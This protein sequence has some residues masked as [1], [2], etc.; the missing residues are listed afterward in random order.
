MLTLRFI[1]AL[2]FFPA[3]VPAQTPAQDGC[4]VRTI[5]AD[6]KAFAQAPEARNY[7]LTKID[8]RLLEQADAMDQELESKG[9]VY[10]DSVTDEYVQRIG[11]SVTPAYSMEKVQ[12]RF[13]VLRDPGVNA[14]ALLFI[15]AGG[16]V[17]TNG[18]KAFN[19]AGFFPF[20]SALPYDIFGIRIGLVDAASG[21]VLYY[22]KS[23][24]RK[25]LVRNIHKADP[26]IQKSLRAFF[27]FNRRTT[28]TVQN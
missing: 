20:M 12:W 13:H 6:E 3:L 4:P 15:Q 28:A 26:G 23:T 25:N 17:L 8:L 11:C 2:C 21:D 1:V 27:E 9:L 16:R 10:H 5:D 22:G 14:D 18:K 7:R 24:V 19:I